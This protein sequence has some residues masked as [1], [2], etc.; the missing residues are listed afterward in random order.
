MKSRINL[1]MDSFFKNLKAYI[2]PYEEKSKD[3]AL[4]VYFYSFKESLLKEINLEQQEIEPFKQEIEP[5]KKE[6]EPF[7]KEQETK[8]I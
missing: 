5:I 6:I 1:L 7:E 8:K 4:D 2:N 3:L